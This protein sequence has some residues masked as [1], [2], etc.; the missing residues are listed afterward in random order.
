M[1]TSTRTPFDIL[2]MQ[3]IAQAVGPF[4]LAPFVEVVTRF[5][6]DPVEIL[7]DDAGALPV[8]IKDGTVRIAGHEDL[9]D[10]HSPL[11]HSV[12]PVVRDLA[13]LASDGHALELDSLP[14]DVARLLASGLSESGII[15]DV[16]EHIVTAVLPLPGTFDEYLAGLS[17]KQRHE[18][19]RKRR[20]YIDHVG[21][22]THEAHHTSGWAFEE[23][24]RLHRL[25]D[26]E[27]GG[28]MTEPRQAFFS[29]LIEL[30]GWRVDLLR[31]PGSD[32][33]AATVFSYSNSDGMYLYNSAYD[34]DLAEG[35]PG[36]AMVEAL[37]SQ[38]ITEG[39]PRFD[40]LKGDEIYKFRLGA[41]PRSLMRVT[42]RRD[43]E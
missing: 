9:T 33:A 21:E 23:F 41:E 40:F 20:R 13:M 5:T 7:G 6:G 15:L 39:L 3:P 36:I 2:G 42:S 16:A 18:V 26:G 8:S 29:E 11:G 19:R 34:P 37:I 22:I 27:K 10:Y 32:R 25:S 1:S 12:D 14:E 43:P 28:F 35:S 38:T 4:P 30:D 24:L 17:K 31:V